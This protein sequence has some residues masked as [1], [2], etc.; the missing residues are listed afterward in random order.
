MSNNNKKQS[1]KHFYFIFV[2]HDFEGESIRTSKWIS[3]TALIYLVKH[4][5]L[6]PDKVGKMQFTCE[7]QANY[8]NCINKGIN[9]RR[10]KKYEGK[11]NDIHTAHSYYCYY[12][13]WGRKYRDIIER[14]N[15]KCSLSVP[16]RIAVIFLIEQF[17]TVVAGVV[18]VSKVPIHEIKLPAPFSH[19][20]TF[21]IQLLILIFSDFCVHFSLLLCMCLCRCSNRIRCL[22]YS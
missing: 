13:S 1:D 17:H 3:K 12:Y 10:R 2:G 6:W 22:S 9:E 20:F 5:I 21:I 4:F 11:N 18:W 8:C 16:Y 7:S 15:C 14:A 19:I